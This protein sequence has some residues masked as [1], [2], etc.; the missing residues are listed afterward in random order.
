MTK[1]TPEGRSVALA[2][3]TTPSIKRMVEVLSQVEERSMI[4]VIE[5][6]IR[7]E[8]EKRGLTYATS[9]PEAKKS[10]T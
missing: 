3:R 9:K 8:F 1:S 5:R 7:A 6:L 10:K 2:L 4:N